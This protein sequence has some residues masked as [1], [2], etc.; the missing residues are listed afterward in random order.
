MS[1][2]ICNAFCYLGVRLV[3]VLLVN[4]QY[5]NYIA[6][7]FFPVRIVIFQVVRFSSYKSTIMVIVV[8]GYVGI[9]AARLRAQVRV[10]NSSHGNAVSFFYRDAALYRLFCPW[11][12]TDTRKNCLLCPNW[13]QMLQMNLVIQPF[14]LAYSYVLLCI[15]DKNNPQ[16]YVCC[17]VG[18]CNCNYHCHW[19]VFVQCHFPLSPS[20]L[21][22][23]L[24][25]VG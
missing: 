8:H 9:I 10:S 18:A 20:C 22:L 4:V 23:S 21:C 7:M 16:R 12:W 19:A 17:F 15:N 2:G 3:G 14:S 13:M 24:S 6:F 11:C 5:I 25:F 1:S